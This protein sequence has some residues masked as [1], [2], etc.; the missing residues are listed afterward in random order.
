[1]LKDNLEAYTLSIVF[2][3]DFNPAI[4]QPFWL[5]N[6]KLIREQEAQNADVRMIHNDLAIF[7]IGWVFFNVSRYRFE[8]KTT[9]EPYF[10]A[11]RD[12]II[13]IFRILKETPLTSIGINHLRYFDLKDKDRYYHFGNKIAPLNL[14][15]DHLNDPRLLSFEIIETQREDKLKGQ[16]RIRIQQP[17]IKIPSSFGVLININDH[18]DIEEGSTAIKTLSTNWSLSFD[19]IDKITESLWDKI[20]S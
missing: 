19:R 5:A 20:N 11:V 6:R 10:E 16:T 8:V 17:D 4:V 12:L 18:I 9:Q 13:E 1:M 3:G 7:D 2:I 15:N 14:W